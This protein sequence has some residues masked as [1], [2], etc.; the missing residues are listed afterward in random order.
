MNAKKLRANPKARAHL[1]VIR[2]IIPTVKWFPKALKYADNAIRWG[3]KRGQQLINF[4]MDKIKVKF[5]Y[6]LK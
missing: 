2:E 3:K 5:I 4:C 6:I 1:E